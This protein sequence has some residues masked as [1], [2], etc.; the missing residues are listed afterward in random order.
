MNAEIHRFQD[1]GIFHGMA[2]FSNASHKL[3][4]SYATRPTASLQN[5]YFVLKAV[6][7][8]LKVQFAADL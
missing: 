1:V 3:V 4:G 7:T 2:E 5:F 8:G 6:N